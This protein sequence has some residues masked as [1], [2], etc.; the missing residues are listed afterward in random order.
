MTAAGYT[1]QSAGTIITG[2]VILASGLNAEYN[3]LVSAFSG[4]TGHDHSGGT[5]LGP[6]LS[7]T[8]AVTG[9]L[10]TANGGTGIAN[11]AASTLTI[12]GA[13][14][15]TLTV[16][17]TTSVTLPTS[18]TLVNSAVATLSSLTSIGTIGTGVW[19]G[20]AITD[21][22]I[23]SSS[24]WNSK[25]AGDATLTALAAYNTNGLLTQ[26]AADTFVGRTLTGTAAEITVT[27]GSGVSG[28]PTLSLPSALTFTGKTITG[29]VHTGGTIENTI[30]GGS[31][32]AAATVT[33]LTASGTVNLSTGGNGQTYSATSGTLLIRTTSTGT[34]TITSAVTG[35]MDGLSIGQSVPVDGTFTNINLTSNTIPG[36]GVYL[37]AANTLALSARSLIGLSLT[38]PASAVNYVAVTGA[39]TLNYPSIASAG[40]DTNIGLNLQTKGTGSIYLETNSASPVVQVVV[41]HTATAVNALHMTGSAAGSDVAVSAQ[42]S[43]TD[44]SLSITAKGA[45]VVKLSPV[46]TRTYGGT[47]VAV[48]DPIIQRVSTETGAVATGTTT[49]PFDDT[50]P[51]N[52]EGDQYMTLAITPK[53]S[54]NILV[55]DVVFMGTCSVQQEMIVALFQDTTANALAAT[56]L[57]TAGNTF[58][59]PVT[60]RHIMTAGT[61][62][63][64]TFKVRAG[65]NAAG[66]TT[67]NGQSAGRIFGGVMASGMM[68]TEYNS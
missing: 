28:N 51:Q 50:I 30:I 46:L 13:F 57:T 68:I 5:G 65:G 20:T 33:G 58:G 8:A 36:N 37:T 23:S 49:I 40:T 43:D 61:T 26:T 6:Q 35:N 24:T 52:T 17:N 63:A 53:N 64:T 16:T 12:S 4:G 42:G 27:N 41:D 22:Y 48:S 47:G 1:R 59:G 11:N 32:P 19:Q 10:P 45:G 18:G 2:A 7:L 62:S 44:I 66:T 15:T 31:T 56:F 9:I 38:N 60:L 29:G 21:T 25:Q 67:F 3:Q 55:I 34:V 14:A 39:T 54:G